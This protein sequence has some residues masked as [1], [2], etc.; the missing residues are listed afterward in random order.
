M[1]AS[2]TSRQ[3]LSCLQY[4]CRRWSTARIRL[5]A[6][7]VR[8]HLQQPS[9]CRRRLRSGCGPSVTAPEFTLLAAYRPLTVAVP[10]RQNALSEGTQQLFATAIAAARASRC[11]M[12]AAAIAPS[13][14]R[15]A[16]GL[17]HR[18][19]GTTQRKAFETNAP[20]RWRRYLP[21][22]RMPA[23]KPMRRPLSL[24]TS[25]AVSIEALSSDLLVRLD[26]I[27]AIRRA[28][29]EWARSQGAR[30]RVFKWPQ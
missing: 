27:E 14:G 29:A 25:V 28:W 22:I 4:G 17:C 10:G 7:H 18:M 15:L 8:T 2:D 3:R 30:E 9:A 21:P 13:V 23:T 6:P 5:E 20:K 19:S 26:N 12:S 11:P 24:P 1:Q 16:R